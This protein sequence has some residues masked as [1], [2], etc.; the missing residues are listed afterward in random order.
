MASSTTSNFAFLGQQRPI[1]HA[2]ELRAQR[3][4][5]LRNLLRRA[6]RLAGQRPDIR[7]ALDELALLAGSDAGTLADGLKQ[8]SLQNLQALVQAHGERLAG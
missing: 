6:A 1:T 4:V 5:R 3:V 8:L 7:T 2:D